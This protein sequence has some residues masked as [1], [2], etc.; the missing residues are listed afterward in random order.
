MTATD[1]TLVR[2][3]GRDESRGGAGGDLSA[4]GVS[5]WFGA[6][7]VLERVSL[8]MRAREVTA[9][10][11]PSGCGKSTFLRI[12]NRMHELV[13]GASLAGSVRLNGSDI[14]WL[15]QS[16][17]VTRRHIGPQKPISLGSFQIVKT[18]TRGNGAV[19]PG[20]V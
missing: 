17:T 5:A 11:G 20:G 9:L 19:C 8:D 13:P 6:R 16:A 7:K 10:I 15:D 18:R 14:Y 1:E 2:P 3:L 4:R 12:L